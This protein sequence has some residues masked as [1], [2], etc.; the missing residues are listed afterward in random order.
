MLPTIGTI[1]A[2]GDVSAWLSLQFNAAYPF[3]SEIDLGLSD[4]SC[5]IDR[6][7]HLDIEGLSRPFRRAINE[8]G[9]IQRG[10]HVGPKSDA[11]TSIAHMPRWLPYIMTSSEDGR[12][13]SHRGLNLFLLN[14]A[15][16]MDLDYGRFVYGG[17]SITQQLVKNLYMTRSKYLGRKLEELLI[18]WQMERVLD[19]SRIL[20]TYINVVEY[21]PRIFGISRAARYYFGKP[22][23]ALTPIEAAYLAALKPCPKCADDHYRSR[24]FTPWYQRRVLEFLTRMRR[25]EIITERQFQ[26]E[27]NTTPQFSGWSAARRAA[28]S[29]WPIPEKR[30][31]RWDLGPEGRKQRDETWRAEQAERAEQRR[32]KRSQVRQEAVDARQRRRQVRLK[33]RAERRRIRRQR[34]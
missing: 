22:A 29:H 23:T 13:R 19:K 11:W 9:F 15:L 30:V 32:V 21:A 4:R 18:V 27:M 1:E 25:N 5:R 14:R 12:F 31:L 33:A 17:S 8:D 34:R 20:E 26:V 24:R 6:F 3:F 16:R 7:E 28:R 10:I 2:A